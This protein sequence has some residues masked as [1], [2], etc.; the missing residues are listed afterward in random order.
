MKNVSK[1]LFILLMIFLGLRSA[2]SQVR[3]DDL[4]RDFTMIIGKWEGTLTYLDY[5]SGK[6][7]VMPANAEVSRIDSTGIFILRN[8]YP[9]E[10]GANSQDTI[11][12]TTDGKYIDGASVV[13]R[14]ENDNGSV[15]ITTEKPGIDGNDRRSAVFKYTYSLGK[16]EFSRKKEVMF[17]GETEWITRHEYKYINK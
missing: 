15:T 14:S 10:P 7:Y 13:S 8:I 9:N 2:G 4:T 17:T 6:P 16:N 12:I 3:Y 5:K 11:I 1:L